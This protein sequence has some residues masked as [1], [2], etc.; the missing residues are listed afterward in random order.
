MG[1]TMWTTGSWEKRPNINI[2]AAYELEP[3][4]T[5][6]SPAVVIE[7]HPGNP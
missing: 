1:A 5:A 7:R 6:L 3:S 2:L 4:L